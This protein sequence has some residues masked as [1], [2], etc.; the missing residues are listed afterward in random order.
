MKR[1][2]S[3]RNGLI[4][5]V[6][7][8]LFL[9]IS[10][11]KAI[12][13]EF[14]E[15]PIKLLVGWRSG[16]TVDLMSRMLA[17]LVANDLGQPVTVVLKPGGS[18]TIAATEVATSK[19][20]GYTLLSSPFI[21]FVVAPYQ[22]KVKYS[23][24]TDFEPL[25][26]YMHGMFGICVRSDSPWKSLKELMEFARENPGEL[27]VSTPGVGTNPH[28]AFETIA[29]K[30]KIEWKHV[31]YPG[32]APAATAL[33]GGHVKVNFGTGSHL[34][35]VDSGNF[36]LLAVD[37]VKRDPRYPEVPTLIELGYDVPVSSN[38]IIAAPKGV[39]E[40]ILRKLEDVFSKAAKSETFNSFLKKIGEEPGGYVDRE[41]TKKAMEA[42]YRTWGK[43]FER[44]NLKTK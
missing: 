38:H 34:P 30:E 20:D 26:T 16:G 41:N 31:P 15:R 7:G 3:I 14:P 12:A 10:F 35:F 40:P 9:T 43:I 22:I 4:L 18:G 6:V 33:L 44:L 28:L 37:A 17:S 13:A 36:R 27:S 24:L 1:N 42:D 11:G 39:P 5:T 29:R 2:K 8:I 19:P 21:C 25:L 23:P 32:G